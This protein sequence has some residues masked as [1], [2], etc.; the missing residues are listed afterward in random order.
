MQI[1]FAA[2]KKREAGN[3]ENAYQLWEKYLEMKFARPPKSLQ[4][5]AAEKKMK[6]LVYMK[7]DLHNLENQLLT[8]P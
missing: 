7:S 1:L 4:L 5:R 6:L 8:N 3:E 2:T